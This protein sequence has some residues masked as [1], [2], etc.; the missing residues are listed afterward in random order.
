MFD[1]AAPHH[2][3][4][5]EL[6]AALP[7]ALQ[8]PKDEGTLDLIVRRPAVGRRDVLDAGELD[9]ETGLAGDT[10]NIRHSRR[11]A[12]GSPHPD[13]QVNVMNSRVIAMIAGEK[14]RWGLA[15]DQL[16]VDL[17]I[18]AA[19]L[20]PGTRLAIGSAVIEVTAQPH[21]GCAKFQGR[22]GT[23]ATNFVNSPRGRALNLRGI[24]ARVVV[25]GRIQ[26]GDRVR[27]L[28][29]EPSA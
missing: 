15:G 5:E 19:N 27:K 7:A 24:N 2:L 1:T 6:E 12:D 11:T 28:G 13:M 10:W 29:H 18:S 21:T 9:L 20:P 26:T 4:L 3:S 22:F 8:S 23:D 14:T 17:D 25:P 16:Y